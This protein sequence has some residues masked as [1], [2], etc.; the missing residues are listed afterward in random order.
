MIGWFQG[1]RTYL[2][3]LGLSL[4]AVL[5]R[6]D[7]LFNDDPATALIETKWL[8]SQTYEAIGI[9]LGGGGLAALR[10]GVAKGK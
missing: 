4:L 7:T 6:L 1:R 5:Y 10:A 3:A 8:A 2:L 9:V